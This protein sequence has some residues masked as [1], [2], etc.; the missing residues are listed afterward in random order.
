M[1]RAIK[2]I[3]RRIWHHPILEF[4]RGRKIKFYFENQEVEGYEGESVAIALY[5]NGIDVLSWTPEGRPRGTFCM[6]GKCS[7]CFMIVDGIPNVRT[8]REPVREGMHISRQRGLPPIPEIKKRREEKVEEE[9]IETDFLIIGG[10]PAGLS[11]ALKAAEYGLR[12][13]LVEDHFKL[14]G[15]LVKQTHKFFGSKELFGGLRGFQIAETLAKKVMENK[16][17]RVLLET[18]A[19]GIFRDGWIGLASK[20]KHYKV[21]AKTIL[22]ATGA[23]ENYLAFPGNDLP[24]VMGAGGAQTIMNEYGVKPG[25]NALV[26]GAGNVGLII[27]YQLLQAGVNVKAIVEIMPQIGG[28]AVHAAKVRRYGV[29][30][31]TQHTIKRVWG[32]ERVEGATIVKVNKK[33]QPIPGTEKDIECDLV[34]L[35]VGLTPDVSLLKQ[36]GAK[37]AWVPELGGLVAYRTKYMETTIPGV[38][39]AGDVKGI[40]E[41]TVAMIEG[42]IAALS[43][44]LRVKK[45]DQK[46]IEEREKLVRILEEYRQS[47]LLARVREGI[48]KVLIKEGEGA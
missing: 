28:W 38:F 34:L 26:V 30:I 29:P 36:I 11:A 4:K 5:A 7:S 27:A 23:Y 43:A 17:I 15:Q 10:G 31:Y 42:Q 44:V 6:I 9:I 33:F 45:N 1:P 12:V 3:D 46:A 21:R 19:Y 20:N 39:I 22:F 35:A 13:I 41:A 47:P 2:K 37:M 18:T 32:E 25:N 40:E 24:G 14:G 16:N 8:C 48:K